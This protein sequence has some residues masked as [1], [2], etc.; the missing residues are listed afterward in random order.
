[1]LEYN[2][3][4]LLCCLFSV[5]S[6]RRLLRILYKYILSPHGPRYCISQKPWNGNIYSDTGSWRSDPS[7]KSQFSS[8]LFKR[9]SGWDKISPCLSAFLYSWG[10]S[11][12]VQLGRGVK[13]KSSYEMY[14]FWGSYLVLPLIRNLIWETM[15]LIRSCWAMWKSMER[16]LNLNA[17]SVSDCLVTLDKAYDFLPLLSEVEIKMSSRL[18]CRVWDDFCDVL[19]K[20]W[21]IVPF[22]IH[23][24]PFVFYRDFYFI[25]II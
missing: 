18:N 9:I 22:F 16:D 15:L 3:L 6:N 17:T 5:L 24:H 4:Q 1:M 11:I 23:A 7:K 14:W 21:T 25:L 2:T 10:S 19:C 12:Y 20:L 8:L 13:L